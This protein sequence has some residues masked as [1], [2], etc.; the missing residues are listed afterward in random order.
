MNN[1]N[2]PIFS[3]SDFFIPTLQIN[4][5]KNELECWLSNGSTGGVITSPPRLGKSKAIKSI[6]NQL[7]NRMNEDIYSA[8]ISIKP[9]DV[10]TI[11]SVFINLANSLK[12][13]YKPRATSDELA[14]SVCHYL[15]KLAM[16]N[17]TN[18]V[19]LFVDEVQRLNTQQLEAFA[20][21]FDELHLIGINLS[22]FFIGN[23]VESE[24]LISNVKNYQNE[25]IRG[26]F[27]TLFC[28]FEGIKTLSELQFCLAQYDSIK[29]EGAENKSI[30][31][32]FLPDLYIKGWRIETLTRAL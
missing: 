28:E 21:I 15:G 18:Q 5:L 6:S 7:K 13:D 22:V 1:F 30:T 23:D 27:F 24:S 9:R 8:Y 14:N 16:K 29:F 19:V 2:H 31:E 11:R 3:Q 26:R 17:N 32:F 4:S 10:S 12:I 20:E 25:L